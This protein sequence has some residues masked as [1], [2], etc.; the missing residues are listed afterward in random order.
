MQCAASMGIN[1]DHDPGPSE[2][3]ILDVFK[4]ERE[5]YGES[6]MSPQLIRNRM[7]DAEKRQTVN[8]ALRQLVAAGWIRQPAEGLYEFVED[9]RE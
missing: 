7:E 8:Y 5:N 1:E 9:P 2:E 6:R 3:R 4:T